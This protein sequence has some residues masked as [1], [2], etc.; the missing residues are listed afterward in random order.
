MDTLKDADLCAIAVIPGL[1]ISDRFG[2]RSQFLLR[3]HNIKYVLSATCEQDVPRWDETT[4]T[5]IS[6]M[7]LDIDDHPMQDILCY[8]KQACDWIHA[9]LEEKPDGTDPQKPVGVLVHCVQGISRSGAIVVAYL[10]RYHSL[11]YSD[12]LSVARKHRPLIAPNPGFEQQ[13]R[14]WELCNYDVY[15][16]GSDILRPEYEFW[17]AQCRKAFQGPEAGSKKVIHETMNNIEAEMM[18]WGTMIEN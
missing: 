3:S 4:L 6:T 5:K 2:A 10:M 9:A 11:S 7:H 1:Y 15:A 8:L 17:K 18:K 13:L 16:A 12:A 14:L